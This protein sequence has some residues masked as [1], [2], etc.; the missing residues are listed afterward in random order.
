[1]AATPAQP[2][3]RHC[4]Q[5]FE[6]ID[7]RAR[8]CRYCLSDQDQ[9]TESAVISQWIRS[10]PTLTISLAAF[11]YTAFRVY[12][13]ADFDVN[14]MLLILRA[15]GITPILVG[16]FLVQLPAELILLTLASCWWIYSAASDAST[17]AAPGQTARLITGS[18]ILP[19]LVLAALISLSFVIIPWPFYAASLLLIG[20]S[21]YAS[22]RLVHAKRSAGP[23]PASQFRQRLRDI[24][25]LRPLLLALGLGVL[26][27]AVAGPAIWVDA[28]VITTTDHGKIVGYVI[29]DSG[30]WMTILTPTWTG[31]LRQRNSIMLEENS[32]ITQREP[33]AITI[34]QPSFF[35]IKMYRP[36][37]LWH[38]WRSGTPV[39]VLTPLCPHLAQRSSQ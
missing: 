38:R 10:H 35:G 2:P 9:P 30:Q 23:S 31:Y 14:N 15:D 26:S 5:C 3:T 7:S 36:I 8:K 4:T 39:P 11:L 32:K 24:G 34:P 17:A 28:E 37:Q 25:V 6:L 27:Y 18:R 12:E 19:L 33:C 22:H 1:M 21:L 20:V 29:D 13:A 16:V